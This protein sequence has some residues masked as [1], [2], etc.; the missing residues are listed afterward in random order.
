MFFYLLQ[1]NVNELFW[2][3]VCSVILTLFFDTPFGNIKKLLF[4]SPKSNGQAQSVL[5]NKASSLAKVSHAE[6]ADREAAGKD[7]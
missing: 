7:L 5:Y 2:V 4:K 1:I 6:T 3:V